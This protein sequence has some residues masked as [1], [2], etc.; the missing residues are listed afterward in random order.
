[1]SVQFFFYFFLLTSVILTNLNLGSFY[2]HAKLPYSYSLKITSNDCSQRQIDIH[3]RSVKLKQIKE[4]KKYNFMHYHFRPPSLFRNCLEVESTSKHTTTSKG[5]TRTLNGPG[6]KRARTCTSG[7]HN[8]SKS[9]LIR[10]DNI[11]QKLISGQS[12]KKI[13]LKLP[14]SSLTTNLDTYVSW[15]L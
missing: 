5:G 10:S 12:P 8:F 13:N 2:P 6:N 14:E 7:F 1:M 9:Q 11:Q 4:E 3:F 15:R